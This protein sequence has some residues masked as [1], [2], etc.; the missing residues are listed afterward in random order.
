VKFLFSAF[1]ALSSL[2]MAGTDA[3][4]IQRLRAYLTD[5]APA[6][7]R[8]LHFDTTRIALER[9]AAE[10]GLPEAPLTD[11]P[12]V[13]DPLWL[14]WQKTLCLGRQYNV[15]PDLSV[16]IDPNTPTTSQRQIMLLQCGLLLQNTETSLLD[17]C[18][19]AQM[20]PLLNELAKELGKS[21]M[22]YIDFQGVQ[23]QAV[24]ENAVRLKGQ[25]NAIEQSRPLLIRQINQYYRQSRIDQIVAD[26]GLL[27]VKAAAAVDL[28]MATRLQE[29]DKKNEA[30]QRR[31][32][33]KT[34]LQRRSAQQK[35]VIRQ[36]P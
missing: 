2:V 27:P 31:Q 15:V 33:Q 18:V 11:L 7:E 10:H 36:Q 1:V 34:V 23:R 24:T 13:A 4:Q 30:E 29:L 6:Q 8:Q 22:T 21:T 35:Q 25:L 19:A 17:R 9:F 5:Q 3:E 14:I 32:E 16:H 12:A 20:Q 28:W 26:K